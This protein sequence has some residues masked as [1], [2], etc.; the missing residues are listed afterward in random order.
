MITVKLILDFNKNIIYVQVPDIVDRWFSYKT[1]NI[2][3][4]EVS[5]NALDNLKL[6]AKT[7]NKL[8]D[9][10]SIIISKH[11]NGQNVKLD[12]KIIISIEEKEK[13]TN[14]ITLHFS[15][16]EIQS[17][18]KDITAEAKKDKELYDI[19]KSIGISKKKYNKILSDITFE[20]SNT[21]LE[22]I[23]Y[24]NKKWNSKK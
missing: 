6:D 16:K 8:I 3:E 9:R 11:I 12:K 15:N 24:V 22:I 5:L 13:K 1:D 23:T 19:F 2:K 17:L 4:I 18:I 7:I 14:K 10:Y 21:E 20:K